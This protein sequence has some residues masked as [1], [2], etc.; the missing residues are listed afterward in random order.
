MEVDRESFFLSDG[1]ERTGWGM[2]GPG[3]E[4]SPARWKQQEVMNELQRQRSALG[5]RLSGAGDGSPRGAADRP[6]AG[7]QRF[8][9]GSFSRHRLCRHLDDGRDVCFDRQAQV[10]HRSLRHRYRILFPQAD[11]LAWWPVCPRPCP[12]RLLGH[13]RHRAPDPAGWVV[14]LAN[15][16]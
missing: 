5:W 16:L 14:R 11:S 7:W 13:A 3:S 9:V 2:H 15:L 12:D 1:E 4:K 6:H 8:L 10:G